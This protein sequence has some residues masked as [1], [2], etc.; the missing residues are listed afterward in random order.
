MG[1]VVSVRL[2]CLLYYCAT[3]R[4]SQEPS[5]S[6]IF[7]LVTSI[8]NVVLKMLNL[9]QESQFNAVTPWNEMALS[10]PR[11]D[12]DVKSMDDI[13]PKMSRQTVCCFFSF[14]YFKVLW[15]W[16]DICY[17]Y[18]HHSS[19]EVHVRN[20]VKNIYKYSQFSKKFYFT[21]TLIDLAKNKWKIWSRPLNIYSPGFSDAKFWFVN[22]SGRMHFC[23]HPYVWKIDP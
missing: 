13:K 5:K 19:I 23:K 21:L 1:V 11:L 18:I 15:L 12:D 3:F 7:T 14:L 22:L 20:S 10:V 16:M 4:N 17:V 9:H 2:G 6:D 8:N